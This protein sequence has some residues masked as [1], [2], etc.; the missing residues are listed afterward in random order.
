MGRLTT[1]VLDTA[2]GRPAEAVVISAYRITSSGR[3][4]LGSFTTNA[5]GRV[6]GAILQGDDFVVG[7]YELDFAIGDYFQAETF[8]T[9]V[10]V[11]FRVSDAAAHHHVPLLVS[12]FGYSTYRGS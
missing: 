2:R 9:T 5:D 11:R 12:P 6:D 4:N 10:T 3:T 8:L 7:E 1:H